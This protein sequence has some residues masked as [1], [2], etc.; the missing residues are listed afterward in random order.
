MPFQNFPKICPICRQGKDFKFIRDFKREGGKFYLYQC[1]ECQVQFWLPLNIPGV[2]WHEK[3]AF[4][5]KNAIKPEIYTG[6]HK[7][8]LETHKSFPKGTRVLDLGCGVGEF[9]FELQ[10][11][12][13]EV[14]GSDFDKESIRI[15]K[16]HFGLKNV[17]ALSFEEFFQKKDLPKF[18]VISFLAVIGYLDNPLEFIQNVK[19]L[20]KPNGM[21]VLNAPS[22]ERM[23]ADLNKWDFP[24]HYFTRWNEQAISNIFQKKGFKI[25]RIDYVEQFK[26]LLEGMTSKF[27]TGLAGKSLSISKNKKT[28]II[29]LKVVYFLGC[30]KDYVVGVIPAAFFWIIGKV[31]K[32]KNGTML[33]EL[34]ES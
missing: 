10:K 33:I 5:I 28:P 18:D 8:F 7:K 27:K 26:T 20:L 15:A 12:G 13:C 4:R 9:I 6:Y 23:L 14:W 34:I 1:L 3:K 25:S 31:F 2:K 19:S 32:R 16:E 24:P 11:R 17:F 30:L 29:F 21:A 22:R